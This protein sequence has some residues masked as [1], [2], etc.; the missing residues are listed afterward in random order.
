MR[1]GRI[2]IPDENNNLPKMAGYIKTVY[3][4][5]SSNTFAKDDRLMKLVGYEKPSGSFDARLRAL[6]NYGL[7]EGRGQFRVSQL[8]KQVAYGPDKS[9]ALL[10]AFLAVWKLLY[11]KYRFELPNRQDWIA[12]FAVIAG[13]DAAEAAKA[14]KYLRRLFETDANFIRS[15]KTEQ[16]MGEELTPPDQQLGSEPPDRNEPAKMQF[17]EVKAGPYYSRMPYT[18]VGRNSIRAF[19]DS[20]KFEEEPK[21]AKKEEK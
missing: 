18:E 5:Y 16:G 2:E 10:N 14:E 4:T 17:I 8:G 1:L 12:T 21:K 9:Q 6:R 3:D 13:C 11:D 7:I 20:L 15:L 19:L